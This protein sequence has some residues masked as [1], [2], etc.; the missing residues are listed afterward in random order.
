MA[1]SITLLCGIS[2]SGKSTWAKKARIAVDTPQ[3]IVLC[4]DEFRM[5]ITG[6]DFYLGAEEA[7]WSAVKT[8]ARVLVGSQKHA[9]LI[10]ATAITVG[11]RGQWIRIAKELEVPI[12]CLVFDVPFG[13]CQ[14][15]NQE[16]IR[17][18]PEEVLNRQANLFECPTEAEGFASVRKIES[19]SY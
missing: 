1:G 12:H 11:Q 7:V 13:I 15:R 4:P 9:I 19:D 2:G 5:A 8:A 17:F 16:R 14:E 18:V 3:Y 10:D 6:Q